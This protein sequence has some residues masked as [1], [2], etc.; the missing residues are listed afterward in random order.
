M[1]A[2]K[3]ILNSETWSM[4]IDWDV[5]NKADSF[6]LCWLLYQLTVMKRW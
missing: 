6:M 5:L 2:Y 1:T 4:T 3:L